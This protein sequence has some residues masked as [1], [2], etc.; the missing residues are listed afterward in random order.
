MG[1]QSRRGPIGPANTPIEAARTDASVKNDNRAD[2]GSSVS[3]FFNSLLERTLSSTEPPR[4]RPLG[5]TGRS[6]VLVYV[7]F[8]ALASVMVI[9][10]DFVSMSPLALRVSPATAG[11]LLFITS[12]GCAATALTAAIGLWRMRTWAPRAFLAWIWAVCSL[13]ATFLAVMRFPPDAALLFEGVFIAFM[14]TLF[15]HGWRYIR[16]VYVR[17]GAL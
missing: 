11:A 4:K 13:T 16:R 14:S 7:A 12:L 3:R 9:P 6:L 17:A 5:I 2:H 10:K 1:R 8:A 15:S